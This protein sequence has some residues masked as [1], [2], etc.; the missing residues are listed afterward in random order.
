[1]LFKRYANPYRYI[2]TLI[3]N[4]RFADGVI[5]IQR[6]ASEDRL[7]EAYLHSGTDKSFNDWK[8]QFHTSRPQRVQA[9][10]K[11]AVLATVEHSQGVLLKFKLKER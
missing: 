5:H 3:E 7:W 11:E 8:A 4:D 1:M 9:M 6:A 2:D 10:S